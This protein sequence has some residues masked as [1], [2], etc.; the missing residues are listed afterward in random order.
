MKITPLQQYIILGVLGFL[1]LSFLFYQFA[2]KP[3]NREISSLEAKRDQ[4]KKDLD[5]AKKIV[6]K[7]VEFKKRADSIQRELEWIQNR[8]PKTIDKPKMVEVVTSLQNRSGVS[9]T[10]FKFSNTVSTS[11]SKD[12]S[13]SEVP[14]NIKFN[15]DYSGLI[16][17]VYQMSL[18]NLVMT[19]RDV[20]VTAVTPIDPTHPNVTLSTQMV[21]SGI[22]AK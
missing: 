14:V 22:Q 13:Y 20:V 1:V 8:I 6:A 12:A 17:F 10:D 2:L 4:E 16:K 5:E 11:S 15:S 21:L 3:I 18:S 9:L 7:Y 19:A